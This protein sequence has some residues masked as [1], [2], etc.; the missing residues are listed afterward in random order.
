MGVKYFFSFIKNRY[1]N[2][3]VP[4]NLEKY[5]KVDNLMIDLNG[6]FH[7]C[8]QRVYGEGGGINYYMTY[9]PKIPSLKQQLETYNRIWDTIVKITELCVPTKRL[10][11]CIDGVAPFSKQTQ[12]RQRRFRSVKEKVAGEWDS[13]V[14][15]PGTQFMD[16]LSKFID[17][18]IHESMMTRENWKN[19][20][21]IFSSE[22]VPQEGEHK[23]IKWVR[24]QS[25]LGE[26][27]CLH[28]MD[29]DLVMLGLTS[30]KKRFTILR[31]NHRNPDEHFVI[32]IDLLS[33][34]LKSTIKIEGLDKETLIRDFVFM[35]F[36]VGNDFLPHLPAIEILEGGIE[37]LFETY[38]LNFIKYGC[39]THSVE[40]KFIL[41]KESFKGFLETLGEYEEDILNNKC[42]KYVGYED[43]ILEECK[44]V[45][46]GKYVV[47]FE[48]YKSIYYS[49]HFPKVKLE[50]VCKKYIEGLQWV[51][52]YY[53]T[54]IT[55]WKWHFPYYYTVFSSDLS[56]YI[57]NYTHIT[58][59]PTEPLSPFEQLLCVLPPFSANILPPPLNTLL[60]EKSP[61]KEFYPS[62]FEVDLEGKRN[63][64]EGIAILPF[65][66][67]TVIQK[68]Y[69]KYVKD[70][71][72][73]YLRRNIINSGLIYKYSKES[74]YK[75]H[76]SYYGLVLN[77]I[78][79]NNF[80]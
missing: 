10:L 65:I 80:F 19:L 33:D 18:K 57:D 2:C 74:P 43:S 66:D 48:K 36:S 35:L 30:G 3:V 56:K 16:N 31:Q 67:L 29:A 72:V 79:T 20:E 7:T 26:S 17:Y 77:K 38:R 39:L 15:T 28:G 13:N 68:Y 63:D 32:D 8:S 76:K 69:R 12:Q 34:N 60:T 1:P 9:K 73:K 45:K 37:V 4:H 49:K 25:D 27:Y 40:G 11:L 22:K 50:E 75:E 6:I 52:N 14:I 24:E 64:W 61:I 23:I 44:T 47:D 53:T 51:L 70:V 71:D 46:D 62:H 54:G 41:R 21:I 59:P 42:N 58:Y 5:G 55:S 78:V